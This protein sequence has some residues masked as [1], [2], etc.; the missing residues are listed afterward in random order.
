MTRMMIAV[1]ETPDGMDAEMAETELNEAFGNAEFT[2][3]DSMEDFMLDK[4]DGM[5]RGFDE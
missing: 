3:W 5:V 1:F 2:V 4:R